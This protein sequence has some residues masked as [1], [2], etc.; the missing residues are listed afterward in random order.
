M[1]RDL[2]GYVRA[3]ARWTAK[4]PSWAAFRDPVSEGGGGV[5]L[6]TASATQLRVEW[7]RATGV[8]VDTFVLERRPAGD[9]PVK[10]G[11]WGVG[12]QRAVTDVVEPVGEDTVRRPSDRSAT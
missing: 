12:A 8:H 2:K 1:K 6:L 5:S 9:D 7:V 11:T 3:G 4:Q 10:W